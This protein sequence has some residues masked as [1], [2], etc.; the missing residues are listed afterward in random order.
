MRSLFIL[1]LLAMMITHAAREPVYARSDES[2]LVIA[3]TFSYLKPDVELLL[4]GGVVYALVPFNVDPHDYQL[5]PSDIE[6]LKRADV[7]VSTGH[8]SFEL[9]IRDLVER[10]ELNTKL[11]DML[12]IPGI[13][14]LTNPVTGQ[15]NYHLP[16][17]DP[18]NYLVFMGVLVSVLTEI[19]PGN[20]NC[21][22]SKFY[23]LVERVTK[24]ILIYAGRFSGNV[25]VD[26]P[27]VQYCVE[28]LGFRV[29]WIVKPEE[30]VQ[31]TP[32]NV[33]KI[34]ELIKSRSLAAVFVTKPE[35]L[36]G[37]R[38]LA[39]MAEEHK[40]PVVEVYSPTSS[41][42]VYNSLLD[43][44]VQI[45]E[46]NLTTTTTSK[47]LI[48]SGEEWLMHLRYA[49]PTVISFIVGFVAGALASRIKRR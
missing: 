36:P 6:L 33:R 3:T 45:K 17:R 49:V 15:P 29:A 9:K 5:R 43:V 34:E 7:I 35:V 12:S 26:N 47:P 25:I 46:L 30:S 10:G 11:V 24:E 4:C 22:Y 16:I 2:Q 37:S 8:T 13:R 40:V 28:W 18:V 41:A 31:V 39:E 48:E 14:I 23:Y 20:G 44:V 32:E 38:L 42:G 1:L 21:Y 27:H 19:D